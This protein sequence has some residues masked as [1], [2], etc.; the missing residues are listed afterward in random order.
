[1]KTLYAI[2]ALVVIGLISVTYAYANK[3]KTVRLLAVTALVEQGIKPTSLRLEESLKDDVFILTY[4]RHCRII[5]QRRN[6]KLNI[7]TNT[8]VETN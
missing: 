3:S 4:D 7:L 5:T 8:C 6:D 1:M 2:L